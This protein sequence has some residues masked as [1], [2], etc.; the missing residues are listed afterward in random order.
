MELQT[1]LITGGFL[2]LGAPTGTFGPL[3]RAAVVKYQAA[4]GLPATGYVG[5]LTRAALN[6][7]ATATPATSD[8]TS[9]TKIVE[10]LKQVLELQK[11]LNA[12]AS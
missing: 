9:L 2:S 8:T 3:T 1:V 12:I 5:S 7:V 6:T 10:L 11:K 4:H